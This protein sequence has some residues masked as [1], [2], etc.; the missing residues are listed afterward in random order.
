MFHKFRQFM[1]LVMFYKMNKTIRFKFTFVFASFVTLVLCFFATLLY[2][3]HVRQT[4]QNM[5]KS[6][7]FAI[8]QSI[9]NFFDSDGQFHLHHPGESPKINQF[10][11][12]QIYHN[13]QRLYS[14][15][16][17]SSTNDFPIGEYAYTSDHRF[18]T[19]A[20]LF[21]SKDTTFVIRA[22]YL[23][24][25]E[26]DRQ[27]KLIITLVILVVICVL[28]STIIAWYLSY[29]LLAPFRQIAENAKNTNGQNAYSFNF[30]L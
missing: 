25:I 7:M 2:T 30:V 26:K 19:Y 21:Y 15:H 9:R 20:R 22:F 28:C 1:V 18:L 12:V 4:Q 24:D 29:K 13:K 27:H 5:Q 6:L 16:D 3:L 23:Q 10:I 14:S 17:I 11:A 8:D